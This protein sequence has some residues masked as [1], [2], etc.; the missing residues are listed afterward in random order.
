MPMI[1]PAEITGRY[2]L[3]HVLWSRQHQ[4]L[5]KILLTVTIPGEVPPNALYRK[6][7]FISSKIL[8]TAHTV[9]QMKSKKLYQI[10]W[11][12]PF[13]MTINQCIFYSLWVSGS[14]YFT[15]CDFYWLNG[16]RIIDFSPEAFC[17]STTFDLGKLFFL[18]VTTLADS[19][20]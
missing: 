2:Q 9:Y 10:S 6:W 19:L 15:I 7:H 11:D 8:W 14:K 5:V 3:V 20:I 13:K 1:I 16:W 17:S 18:T 4:F 12:Y